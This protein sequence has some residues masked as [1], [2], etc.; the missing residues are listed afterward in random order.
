[1][2]DTYFPDYGNGG[3]DVDHYDIRVRYWPETDKLTGTTT[4]LAHSTQDLSRFNLDF[5]LDVSSVRVNN[6]AATFS[7]Q[8]NHE[9]VV[10]PDRPVL[11]GAPLTVV[12][13]Y[14]G[15]PSEV[16]V[17]GYTGWNRTEDGAWR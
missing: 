15:I 7:R 2:G 6:R 9:L 12:V 3:Y 4:I 10:T 14:F 11:K 5:V 8:G 13:Q 16:A 1:M 17:N